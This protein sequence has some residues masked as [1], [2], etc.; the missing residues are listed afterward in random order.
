MIIYPFPFWYAM[1]IYRHT[2]SAFPHRHTGRH[3]WRAAPSPW[4]TGCQNKTAGQ[5]GREED[6]RR[7]NTGLAS[8]ELSIEEMQIALMETRRKA[9]VMMGLLRTFAEDQPVLQDAL[10]DAVDE[11]FIKEEDV[12]P[13]SGGAL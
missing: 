12:A 3:G 7:K 2:S 9:Q 13:A 11:F 6:Q 1:V 5:E 4:G 10:A 8:D